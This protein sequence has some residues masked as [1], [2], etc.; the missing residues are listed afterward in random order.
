MKVQDLM[1]VGIKGSVLALYRSSGQ[2]AWSKKVGNDFVNV[3]VQDGEVY[4]S[5][6]GE[7]VCLHAYTGEEVWRNKLKGYGWGLATI[8]FDGNSSGS[9]AAVMSEK[10]RRDEQ[11][12]SAAGAAT[13]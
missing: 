10:R 7:V 5:S 4:A 11:S 1:F 2:I 6:Q 13:T 9:G 12:S 8:A 3:V